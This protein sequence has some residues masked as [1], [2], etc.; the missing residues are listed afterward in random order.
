MPPIVP[1]KLVKTVGISLLGAGAFAS[2]AACSTEAPDLTSS[3]TSAIQSSAAPTPADAGS[4]ANAQSYKAGAYTKPG[5]YQ[6][7]AGEESISVTVNI[8]E[9][10]TI[11]SAKVD[12]LGKNPQ[13]REYEKKFASGIS[14]EVVGKKIAD[15][16]VGKV[17]GSSLT[18]N[19][20][21]AAIAEII[22]AA[23]V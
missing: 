9:D 16:N 22:K 1:S 10:G 4:S 13:S 20:F 7:P 5:S 2:L 19:G 18:G 17:S 12:P 15:L 3:D 11:T 8:T 14:G 6:S 21:N 23:Q